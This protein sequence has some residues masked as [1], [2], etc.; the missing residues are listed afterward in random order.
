MATNGYVWR[1]GYGSNIGLDTLKEKKNLNPSK[2]FVGTIQG[3]QLFFM[4]GL[5]YVEPGWAAVRPTSDP[6]MELHGSAFL[7]PEDEAQG[8]DQQEAGY[9]VTPCRF[10]SYDGEVTENVG[11]YV[12]KNVDKKEEGT[13]SLRYL[14]LLR[15]GARQ[16]G[17]SKEWI[18]QLDSVE[19]Y[20]TPSDV[21]AQTRQWITDFHNDPDRNDVLWSAETLAKHDGT[22]LEKYPIHSSVMEYIVKVDPDMWIFPSWKGHNITRRNLLQFN[23]KSIDKNDIRFNERGY[24]PLPKLSKCSDEEKEYLMQNMERLLHQGATIVAR[25]EPFLDDQK[26]EDTV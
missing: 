13:P 18:H 1:F 21:R 22:N 17:L 3:Y 10:T 8:L 20:I 16:G 7:I 11:V 2:Y 9:T 6:H 25:L 12:P 19:H 15:N 14:G 26:G 5:D 4:K 24:R 23:G